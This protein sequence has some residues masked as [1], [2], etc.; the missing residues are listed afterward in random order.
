MSTWYEGMEATNEAELKF[1]RDHAGHRIS[2]PGFERSGDVV[3]VT[4]C[5][6]CEVGFEVR[7]GPDKPV[8][9]N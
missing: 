5:L 7:S 4:L 3:L 9:S 1:A 8:T 6:D 2:R